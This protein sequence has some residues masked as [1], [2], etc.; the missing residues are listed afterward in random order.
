[1]H[2]GNK[3]LSLRNSK[4]GENIVV[5]LLKK[6]QYISHTTETKQ[7]PCSIGLISLSLAKE[8]MSLKTRF[9]SL[10]FQSLIA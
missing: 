7:R 1:M 10:N 4:K 8:I 3:E 5:S 9:A 2:E 6:Q